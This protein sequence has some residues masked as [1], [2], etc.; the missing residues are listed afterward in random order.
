MLLSLKSCTLLLI[1]SSTVIPFPAFL[2]KHIPYKLRTLKKIFVVTNTPASWL[3]EEL[4]KFA[5]RQQLLK[6]LAGISAEG[7]GAA[8]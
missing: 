7:G 6:C 5:T 3:Y 1:T 4:V 2:L 8:E